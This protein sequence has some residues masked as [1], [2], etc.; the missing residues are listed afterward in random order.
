MVH[1][2]QS[3]LDKFVMI[4]W[5]GEGVPESR[6]GLFREP[7]LQAPFCSANTGASADSAR[8]RESSG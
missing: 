8:K 3:S 1:R 2:M 6:K 5:C 7:K 4:A